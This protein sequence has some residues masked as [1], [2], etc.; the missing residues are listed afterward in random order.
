MWVAN[1]TG[2][3]WGE[4]G[5]AVLRNVVNMWRG[6]PITRRDYMNTRCVLK[7][8]HEAATSHGRATKVKTNSLIRS[9]MGLT[10]SSHVTSD[11]L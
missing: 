2:C 11:K 6:V 10:H 3:M 4:A 5:S 7:A 1:L 9:S 8:G